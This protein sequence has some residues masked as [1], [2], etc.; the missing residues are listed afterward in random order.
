MRPVKRSTS[1]RAAAGEWSWTRGRF[2]DLTRTLVA[3][4][5]V[6]DVVELGGAEARLLELP[7]H[8][9]GSVEILTEG[10]WAPD[11]L[12]DP[13]VE[14]VE[15]FTGSTEGGVILR[16]RDD[17]GATLTICLRFD[18]DLLRAEVPA[19]PG[20]PGRGTCYLVRT[21]AARIVAALETTARHP[22]A[23]SGARQR[24]GHRGGDRVRHRP[25]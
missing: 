8:V 21:R 10:G 17:A 22:V 9:D 13:F 7:W 18:G 1:R 12:D 23:R 24:R 14:R 6:L 2:G 3:G 11:R 20:R 16:A 4:P 5:Y 25:A 19:R 15:R